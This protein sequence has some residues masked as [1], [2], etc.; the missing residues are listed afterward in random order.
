MKNDKCY[1][2]PETSALVE[3]M[4]THFEDELIG[5]AR[6][7][8]NGLEFSKKVKGWLHNLRENAEA[9]EGARAFSTLLEIGS[10][11]RIEW[12]DVADLFE[13]YKNK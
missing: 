8:R 9:H 5:M 3:Q 1:S 12:D 7:S 6:L 10:V 2:N 11:H 4:E 13:E